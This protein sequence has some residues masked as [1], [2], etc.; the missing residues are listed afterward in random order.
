MKRRVRMFHV[1]TGNVGTEMIGRIME[2][3]D[4][5]LRAFAS[6]FELTPHAEVS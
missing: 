1:P 6:D 3:A 2:H 5:P 4:L